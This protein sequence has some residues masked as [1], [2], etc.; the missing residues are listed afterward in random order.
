M[1][2]DVPSSFKRPDGP[3]SSKCWEWDRGRDKNGYGRVWLN[4]KTR[5][6]HR[7]VFEAIYGYMP[8]LIMHRCDNPPCFNPYHLDAGNQALNAQDAVRKGRIPLG[9]EN[10]CSKLTESNIPGI[11]KRLEAGESCNSIA[12]SFNVHRA[13]IWKI[14]N[15]RRFNHVA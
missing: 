14:K 6:V 15:G 9:S 5:L 1:Q 8:E 7:I 12:K 10:Y 2:L 11:R 4:G 13:T 3:L